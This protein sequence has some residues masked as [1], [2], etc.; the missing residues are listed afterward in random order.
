MDARSKEI[1]RVLRGQF[2][3]ENDGTVIVAT[4]NPL[5]VQSD[6]MYFGIDGIRL[7]G[8]RVQKCQYL[9]PGRLRDTQTD[10]VKALL[11]MGRQVILY[12]APNTLAVLHLSAAS[13]PTVLTLDAKG[14]QLLFCVY[15][16][17]SLLSRRRAKRIVAA[18]EHTMPENLRRTAAV[19]EPPCGEAA[20]V[21]AE[22]DDGTS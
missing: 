14:N 19:L 13:S 12:S 3:Y 22:P 17:R 2:T 21:P 16:K 6:G 11:Q 10:C 4:Q 15:G 5:R 20:D 9:I 1:L 7:P 18:W 8:V